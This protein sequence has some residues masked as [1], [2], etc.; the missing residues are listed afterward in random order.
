ML[1]PTEAAINALADCRL[2]RAAI[3]LHP[4]RPQFG[5]SPICIPLCLPGGFPSLHSSD[6]RAHNPGPKMTS[7]FLVLMQGDYCGPFE[8]VQ[9]R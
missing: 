8:S 2:R 4:Q 6:F 1:Q 3:A 9:C 7:R 5:F